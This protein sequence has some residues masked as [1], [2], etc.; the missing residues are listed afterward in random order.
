VGK[1]GRTWEDQERTAVML[2][3][4]SDGLDSVGCGKGRNWRVPTLL[5]S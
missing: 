3:G 5:L 4:L 2:V 1:D